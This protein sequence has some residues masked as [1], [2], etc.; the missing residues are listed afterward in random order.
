MK[1]PLLLCHIYIYIYIYI[2]ILKYIKIFE[3]QRFVYEVTPA[4]IVSPLEPPT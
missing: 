2:Y 4:Y 3:D 1:F